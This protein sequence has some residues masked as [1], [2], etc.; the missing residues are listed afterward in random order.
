MDPTTGL[1]VALVAELLEELLALAP[2]EVHA[3]LHTGVLVLLPSG[4]QAGLPEHHSWFLFQLHAALLGRL[5]EGVHLKSLYELHKGPVLDG[6]IWVHLGRVLVGLRSQVLFG[7]LLEE[8]YA[9][10]LESGDFLEE[11]P[12]P[13]L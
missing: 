4:V 10:K 12:A 3:G 6:S 11:V 1:V 13:E 8:V 9:S 2:C 7:A 5:L